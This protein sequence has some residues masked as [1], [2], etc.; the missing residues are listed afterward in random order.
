M[1]GIKQLMIFKLSG[2]SRSETW[3]FTSRQVL[4]PSN[5]TNGSRL[6]EVSCLMPSNLA[7][8]LLTPHCIEAGRPARHSRK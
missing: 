3:S 2:K 8:L 7:K 4:I 5:M 1:V 6:L